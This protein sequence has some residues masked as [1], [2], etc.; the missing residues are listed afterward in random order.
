MITPEELAAMLAA[1]ARC[2]ADPAGGVTRLVYTPAWQ[3]AQELVAGWMAAAGLAVRRDAAGNLWGRAEGRRGGPAVVTGSHLD[4]VPNGGAYDGA[5][6]IVAGLAAVRSLLARHGAPERPLEVVAICEEENSRF[7]AGFWGSRAIAGRIRPEEAGQ[8]RDQAGVTIGEAMAAAGL[9]PAELPAAR[10]T[11][12]AAFL[13][14]HIEQGRVLEEAGAGLGVV[15]TVAGQTQLQVTVHGNPDHAG[16][17]PM[18]LRRDALVGAAEMVARIAGLARAAGEPAVAT[19]GRIQAEPGAPNVIPGRVTF[20]VDIRAGA[21]AQQEAL[22]AAIRQALAEIAAAGSLDL[23]V[24]VLQDQPP[25]PM[26]PHLRALLAS[27]ADELGI[28]HRPMMSGA[29]H[30]AMVLA[31]VAPAALLFVPSRGGRS[32][33]PEEYTA[34]AQCAA[35]ASVLARALFRLAYEPGEENPHARP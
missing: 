29:G 6:G 19:V 1:L 34:P 28:S 10:R 2:G 14:L 20:S 16:S 27:A 35:G 4:T 30:D 15:E 18:R 12:I 5:L 23:E 26:A 9:P 11:D 13:E 31:G 32:H 7:R 22:T 21:R 3:A 33:C 25:V 8:L 24:A 17:T